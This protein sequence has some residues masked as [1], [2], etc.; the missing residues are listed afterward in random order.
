MKFSFS[1]Q[2]FLTAFLVW[3]TLPASLDFESLDS[4]Q[5]AAVNGGHIVYNTGAY[6]LSYVNSTTGKSDFQGQLAVIYL[7]TEKK[8]FVFDL[9][10]GKQIFFIDRPT[11]SAISSEPQDKD[12][13]VEFLIFEKQCKNR[14]LG[15]PNSGICPH[16]VCHFGDSNN[17]T[18]GYFDCCTAAL[19]DY[20]GK[21]ACS[22]AICKDA[23]EYLLNHKN[24]GCC[25]KWQ[26]DDRIC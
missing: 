2:F 5:K 24:G 1:F 16:H 22:N 23:S 20:N 8:H 19:R 4:A 21:Y 12:S 25:N 6:S 9:Y 10:T 18:G 11:P 3:A 17:C 14:E 7:P 13:S 26:E 15:N